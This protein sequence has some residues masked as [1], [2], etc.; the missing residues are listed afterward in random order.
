MH[1]GN[2]EA[3]RYGGHILD[4]LKD[5]MAKDIIVDDC[6]LNFRLLECHDLA[7]SNS[8]VTQGEALAIGKKIHTW[9]TATKPHSTNSALQVSLTTIDT[10]SSIERKYFVQKL[11]IMYDIYSNFYLFITF[12]IAN[13]ICWILLNCHIC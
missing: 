7:Y 9:C 12:I 5:L 1:I 4:Q 8:L 6:H 2:Q 13:N 3:F 11:L 10:I